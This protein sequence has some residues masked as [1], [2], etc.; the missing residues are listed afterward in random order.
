MIKDTSRI[1]AADLIVA[2][3]AFLSL[4][5]APLVMNTE[6]FA[7]MSLIIAVGMVLTIVLDFGLSTSAIKRYSEAGEDRWLHALAWVKITVL[8][9]ALPIA[10]LIWAM[11]GSYFF[12]M[13]LLIGAGMSL[14]GSVRL[15]D[16]ARQRFDAYLGSNLKLAAFRLVSVP[17]ALFLAGTAGWIIIALYV[18]P[19]AVLCALR[20]RQEPQMLIAPAKATRAGLFSY[21][22]AVY[23]SNVAYSALPYLPQLV[24]HNRFDA[25]A[26]ASFGIVTTFI[27]PFSMVLVA[28]RTYLT[29]R[30]LKQTDANFSSPFSAAGA[31]LLG[32]VIAL[33]LGAVAAI[34][35]FIHLVYGAK[36]PLAAGLFAGFGV[37]FVLTSMVGLFNIRLHAHSL[38]QLDMWVNIARV[39][40]ACVVLYFFGHSPLAVAM[41]T[42]L[43]MFVGEI[44]LL[45]WV[46]RRVRA[47]EQ[48][49]AAAMEAV[50]K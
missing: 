35:L 15:L 46:E 9:I 3:T 44:A 49:N 43:V 50:P 6:Q 24:L 25:H 16:S 38:P 37:F 36:Y 10:G 13:S 1:L 21:A 7:R 31:K 30:I 14:W 41:L 22:P 4:S 47:I 12:A 8:A 17:P 39:I 20:A 5:I 18:A 33:G 2:A 23:V 27:A 42:G 34:T 29:P 28:L 19:I 40:G 45:F 48:T 32:S 11:H 26:V